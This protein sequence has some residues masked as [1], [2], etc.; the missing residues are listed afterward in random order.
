MTTLLDEL[1]DVIIEG[2]PQEAY[3]LTEKGLAGR[4]DAN[5]LINQA[6]IP[7]MGVVGDLFE[8]GEYFLPDMMVAAKAMEASMGLLRPLLTQAD[9]QLV[10]TI[11]MGTVK[12]DLHDIGKNLVGMM[13]EG[14]GFKVIDLGIDV[15][16][17]KFI[18][19]IQVHDAALVGMSALLSTTAPMM[20][21][22]IETFIE[23]GVRDR[24]KVMIGGAPLTQDYADKIGADGYAPNASAAAKKA[25]LLLGPG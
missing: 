11:I 2:E 8:S 22:I 16:A 24:V 10:A 4:F 17:Q 6:L 20:R 14:A 21:T 18:D 12:G 13:M 19:A 23:A 5:T 7:A 25:K 9:S 15:T 3:A 1:Q